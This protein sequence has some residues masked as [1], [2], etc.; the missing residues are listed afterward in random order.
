MS[1]TLIVAAS[2]PG[3][4]L[5]GAGNNVGVAQQYCYCQVEASKSVLILLQSSAQL[6][7]TIL[8]SFTRQMVQLNADAA[9][10]RNVQTVH[11]KDLWVLVFRS[12]HLKLVFSEQSGGACTL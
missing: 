12:F 1:V 11:D 3:R 2:S 6:I 5:Q 10:R 9:E 7:M 4:S 8:P